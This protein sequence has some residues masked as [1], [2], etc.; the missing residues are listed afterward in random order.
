MRVRHEVVHVCGRHAPSVRAR[1]HSA[2][3][4]ALALGLAGLAGLAGLG[5]DRDAHAAPVDA[6]DAASEKHPTRQKS[7]PFSGCCCWT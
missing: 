1:S 5:V 7:S 2:A 6:S 4:D 3:E